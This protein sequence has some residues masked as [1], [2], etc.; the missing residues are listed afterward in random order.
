MA[1]DVDERMPERRE[2]SL[3]ELAA[4]VAARVVQRCQHDVELFEDRVL[5]IEPAV[6]QDVDLDAVQ[7]RHPRK[8]LALHVDL[9]AL[10]GDVVARQ[11][12]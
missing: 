6:P 5:E 3:G 11:R 1:E 10:P 8:A 4:G 7:D 12:P 9:L 2:A